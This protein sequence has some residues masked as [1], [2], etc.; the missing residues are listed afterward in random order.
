MTWDEVEATIKAMPAEEFRNPTKRAIESA[1]KNVVNYCRYGNYLG[2]TRVEPNRVG[3]IAFVWLDGN[4]QYDV[5]VLLD[6]WVQR[7]LLFGNK[8]IHTSLCKP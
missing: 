5:D 6:G 2:P 8:I 4:V 3:G 7:T 1:I